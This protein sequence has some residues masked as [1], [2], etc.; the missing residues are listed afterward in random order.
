MQLTYIADDSS[1]VVVWRAKCNRPQ[2][3]YL[4]STL[5]HTPDVASVVP[6]L[7]LVEM[8][9]PRNFENVQ[10]K[11]KGKVYAHTNIVRPMCV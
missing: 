11:P 2:S 6:P 9:E 3:T 7:L 10:T 5:R 1:T 8:H 4:I